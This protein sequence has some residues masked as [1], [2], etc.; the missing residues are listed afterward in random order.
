MC[1]IN[2][3]TWKDPDLIEK[4]NHILRHRGPDDQSTYIDDKVSL[5]H[6]RLAIIDLSPA[7][8]QPKCNEDASIWIVFNGEIYNFRDIRTK[9]EKSGHQFSSN[10]DTEVI[11][12]AYEEWGV[13][14]VE[15]FNGM[16]AFAIYDKK[17][18]TIFFSRDRFGV[19]PLYFCQDEKG[20]IFSSE[21]K[22]ILQHSIRR[23][24][25]DKAVYDFLVL[26]FVDHSP[27]T[28]FMGIS[29]LMPG[30]SMIYDL[31]KGT[32][33]RFRW[34]DLASR[35]S[36]AGKITEEEA[37]KRIRELFEDSVRY[38]LISDVPV[39]SCLS[40]GIDSSSIVYAMRKMNEMGE[41][42]TFSMVF[43]GKK[44]DESSF[45]N[46]VVAATKVEAHRVSPTT[47]DLL[48]DLNDL[49]W[50]QEEP[51]GSLS[52]YGQYKV[53]ELANRRGMKVL[54]D[55]K[56]SDE[57]F[58]GYFIYYKYYLFESLLRLRR[59]EFVETSK[60]MK[61]KLRD[62]V[63]FPAMTILS[64]LGLSQGV[65]KNLWLSRIKYLKGFD[66]IVLANP[67]TDRG[68]DLNRALH[69]DLSRYSIPQ[70]L[71]YEDKNSMRWS[72]ESRVPFLDYR[73]VELAMSLPS[74]YK[75]QK[76][77][78]KYILRK[79]MKGLVSERILGRKD[80][81]GF[82]TP[83]ESWMKASDFAQFMERLINSEEFRLR[84]YWKPEEV[85][86][87]LAEHTSG[88]KNHEEALWRIM[89]VELWL[90][91]FIDGASSEIE[92]TRPSK[93]DGI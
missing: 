73:L 35:L 49:I 77:T 12:H 22:G 93:G 24:P 50:T 47:E 89:S 42:K 20:L 87:L 88:K 13:D 81:I 91:S 48:R 70:L 90:R 85:E 33:N 78:T 72:I 64:A 58:A 69:S 19:K 46:E 56:G 75:I 52:I 79:A 5:G 34:Y 9:L 25:S 7:G 45:I 10:T 3:F 23:V 30:E 80:K 60:R 84:K 15:R 62:M 65:L 40:G 18:G 8:R 44:Q 51:F 21:I 63:L 71:R 82:A 57:I 53:M 76:G 17:K 66:G 61:S 68:F 1:G 29:R 2:G 4:M 31:P 11:I 36:D 27:D 83:D 86:R 41:I 59:E 14:C 32:M 28:F 26:G 67:L 16:W 74:G 38:R 39:G 43:P 54:L 6:R 37:A 55:G 92:N